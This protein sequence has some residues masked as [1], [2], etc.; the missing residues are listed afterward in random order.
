M[1]APAALQPLPPTPTETLVLGAGTNLHTA[2]APCGWTLRNTPLQIHSTFTLPLIGGLAWWM[3]RAYLVRF[4]SKPKPPIQATGT[5]LNVRE[6][7]R[8]YSWNLKGALVRTISQPNK[9]TLFEKRA[10]DGLLRFIK[11]TAFARF[12]GDVNRWLGGWQ[13]KTD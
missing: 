8:V 10:S 2:H 13:N 12:S 5:W 9:R 11:K 3:F 6:G 1:F 7:G 4:K